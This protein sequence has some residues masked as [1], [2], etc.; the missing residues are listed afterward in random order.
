[1]SFSLRRFPAVLVTTA[2]ATQRSR[3]INGECSF[4]DSGDCDG[5][6]YDMKYDEFDHVV[7]GIPH[8]DV[9]AP[10][11]SLFAMGEE[12]TVVTEDKWCPRQLPGRIR[13]QN[14]DGTFSVIFGKWGAFQKRVA[15][16]GHDERVQGSQIVTNEIGDIVNFKIEGGKKHMQAKV[17][18]VECAEAPMLKIQ[19]CGTKDGV[20][21]DCKFDGEMQTMQADTLGPTS[22]VPAHNVDR[23][24]PEDIIFFRDAKTDGAVIEAIIDLI[25]I[26]DDGALESVTV[27]PTKTDIF[28]K[29]VRDNSKKKMK[30]TP[31]TIQ[32]LK[33][34]DEVELTD[35]GKRYLF[36]LYNCLNGC[37]NFGKGIVLGSAT[38]QI[39]DAEQDPMFYEVRIGSGVG[40]TVFQDR[41]QMDDVVHNIILH[42]TSDQ[43]KLVPNQESI[44]TCV[45]PG[46]MRPIRMPGRVTRYDHAKK[47][48]TIEY[49]YSTLLTPWTGVGFETGV[50]EDRIRAGIP[51]Q[52]DEVFFE[53]CDGAGETC[54]AGTCFPRKE[55]WRDNCTST[56]DQSMC[57]SKKTE[58]LVEMCRF[59]PPARHGHKA[60]GR[61]T[62]LDL[63]NDKTVSATFINQEYQNN[64]PFDKMMFTRGIGA[65]ILKMKSPKAKL[66]CIKQFAIV[67]ISTSLLKKMQEMR[68]TMNKV[69]NVVDGDGGPAFKNCRESFMYTFGIAPRVGWPMGIDLNLVKCGAEVIKSLSQRL[70]NSKVGVNECLGGPND[71]DTC[72]DQ[73]MREGSEKEFD[74]TGHKVLSKSPIARTKNNGDIDEASSTTCNVIGHLRVDLSLVSDAVGYAK[75]LAVMRAQNGLRSNLISAGVGQAKTQTKIIGKAALGFVNR[76]SL[77]ISLGVSFGPIHKCVALA[78]KSAK[79]LVL[80]LFQLREPICLHPCDPLESSSVSRISTACE[81]QYSS[82]AQQVKKPTRGVLTCEKRNEILWTGAKNHGERCVY[83]RDEGETCKLDSDCAYGNECRDKTELHTG[84]CKRRK[85]IKIGGQFCRKREDCS[86][87]FEK[88]W[89][90]KNMRQI[91][92]C[93]AHHDIDP[94]SFG[95]CGLTIVEKEAYAYNQNEAK[96][97]KKSAPKKVGG[98]NCVKD[99]ECK[100]DRPPASFDACDTFGSYAECS[101]GKNPYCAWVVVKK[102]D[103]TF[104][105]SCVQVA[106]QPCHKANIGAGRCLR[107]D[108]TDPIWT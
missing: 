97:M 55:M 48:Y 6:T 106:T 70:K 84:T 16:F 21:K 52:D 15:S 101:E 93:S 82:L 108:L 37:D 78:L 50:T 32:A 43:V 83:C 65:C 63:A 73:T 20:T 61:I 46:S 53:A 60:L 25:T 59:E 41:S 12:V 99:D 87:N 35:A 71:P 11:K 36:T 64:I 72:E 89:S 17:R 102:S 23:F 13:S 26:G 31:D 104:E 51:K 5:V 80:S 98:V 2:A 62:D 18:G 45:R 103:A 30:V 100:L 42:L 49:G 33:L 38:E 92:T 44:I 28:K 54:N 77:G 24:D 74:D 75:K 91:V 19:L 8:K 96:R 68:E 66:Q 9:T 95:V 90:I 10:A 88:G 105:G 39:E 107:G 81:G 4:E 7:C 27:A 22:S 94:K 69:M 56:F 85:G 1:M 40:G 76:G 14:K 3:S 67:K 34:G 29:H 47:E 86:M 58:G 57:M 79:D